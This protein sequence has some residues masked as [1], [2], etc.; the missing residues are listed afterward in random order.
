MKMKSKT[1]K[2]KI[3]TGM[4]NPPPGY[5]ERYHSPSGKP[6]RI[7]QQKENNNEK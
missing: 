6:E 3:E 4:V 7:F 1:L 5:M 2:K